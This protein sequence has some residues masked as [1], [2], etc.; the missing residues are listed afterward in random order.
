MP[1]AMYP[2]A[3]AFTVTLREATS[4]ATALVN[5]IRPC[6]GCGIVG[7]AGVSGEAD[8]G[9]HVDDTA[10]VP[11]VHEVGHH[12]LGAQERARAG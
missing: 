11:D 6:L 12:V 4:R 7:L 5:P 2:G 3:T 8:H 1:V 9:G 10:I